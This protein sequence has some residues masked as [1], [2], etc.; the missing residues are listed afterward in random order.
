MKKEPQVIPAR[1]RS[2]LALSH[3]REGERKTIRT[4]TDDLVI[5]QRIN[6]AIDEQSPGIF[7][8]GEV[9]LAV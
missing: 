2:R 3:T 7:R 8:S 4:H 9:W 1:K 5:H 6:T